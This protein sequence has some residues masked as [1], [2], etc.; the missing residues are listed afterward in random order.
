MDAKKKQGRARPQKGFTLVELLVVIAIIGV[1]VALLLPAVQAARE[2]A[3]RNSCLNNIKQLALAIHNYADRKSEEFPLASMA[4]FNPANVVGSEQD[5]YSWLFTIMQELEGGNLYNRVRNSQLPNGGPIGN[6]SA[7]LM[8]GPF[9]PLVIVDD[10]AVGDARFAISQQ[11]PAFICPSYP[12]AETT[13]GTIYNGQSAA[14]GNYVAIPSTHYNTDGALPGGQDVG[15]AGIVGS[16]FDSFS[17][18]NPKARAGNG[19]LVFAQPRGTGTPLAAGGGPLLSILQRPQNGQRPRGVKFAGIRDGTSNTVM[20]T[21]SR[22]ESYAAWIS[23]LSMYVVAA[24]PNGPGQMVQKPIPPAGTNQPAVL[25]W[26]DNDPLGQTALNVG[27]SVKLAGGNNA[28]DG[29]NDPSNNMAFFYHDL[30]PH[31]S[32]SGDPK[33]WYGPSSAHPGSVMH[34]FADGHGKAINDDIDR[35]IYLQIVT[36]AG[37][38]VPGEF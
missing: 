4:Y 27:D 1:L 36:R 30:Y 2:A 24:D 6:G 9:N 14:V 33:R 34:G 16:L 11:V 26:L 23:G 7:G 13:R 32:P 25:Q 20:F 8:Q 19:V 37:G 28:T 18:A 31:A 15:G 35:D 29:P 22:E 12:G 21:E 3:R 5:G 17:G 10:N 38:E